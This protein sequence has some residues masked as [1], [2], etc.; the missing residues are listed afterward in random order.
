MADEFV[1][2]K[3][4]AAVERSFEMVM[5]IKETG[6]FSKPY[7]AEDPSIDIEAV[8]GTNGISIHVEPPVPGMHVDPVI[9]AAPVIEIEF[10]D[11][12]GPGIVH[13][14]TPDWDLG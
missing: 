6:D 8:W 14:G 13:A 5:P 1:F 9:P 2:K 10:Y 3:N 7:L 11:E 12:S 4:G